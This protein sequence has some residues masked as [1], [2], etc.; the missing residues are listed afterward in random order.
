MTLKSHSYHVK[1]IQYLRVKNSAYFVL[2]LS[3]GL[4][5]LDVVR[6]D[7]RPKRIGVGSV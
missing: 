7:V 1:S 6:V 4:E 3:G 2:T 5:Q